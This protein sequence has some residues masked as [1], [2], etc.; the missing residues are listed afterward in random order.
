MMSEI[1]NNPLTI[2][3]IAIIMA[4]VIQLSFK[5][6]SQY[7]GTEQEQWAVKQK[8]TGKRLQKACLFLAVLGLFLSVYIQ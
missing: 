5:R 4:G 1:F 3:F 8:V 6:F 2:T 7:Q